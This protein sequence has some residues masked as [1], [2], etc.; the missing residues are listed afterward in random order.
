MNNQDPEFIFSKAKLAEKEEDWAQASGLYDK[1]ADALEHE[2]YHLTNDMDIPS[3]RAI[4]Y[5]RSKI[6]CLYNVF[7]HSMSETDEFDL[8]MALDQIEIIHEEKERL[9]KHYPHLL[10][11]CHSIESSFLKKLEQW[12]ASNGMEDE[13]NQV[14]LK[15]QQMITH[16]LRKELKYR[17][18]QKEYIQSIR[19]LSKLYL[20]KIFYR[21]YLGYGINFKNLL[22]SALVIILSFTLIY[23]LTQPLY[24]YPDSSEYPLRLLEAFFAS[25]L[26]F[27]SLGYDHLA[28]KSIVGHLL[29][30]I[31]GILGFITF[32]GIIAYIW[33][34][35]NR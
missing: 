19:G 8:D 23:S 35:M 16:F 15:N 32:G 18:N 10:Y 22:I 5:F 24:S 2:V 21:T 34:R 20:R 29:V 13:S 1:A 25:I 12:L 4:F 6:N 3:A 7:K 26:T 27:I 30:S 17:F 33:R 28:P 14:F 11:R 31:E 9:L